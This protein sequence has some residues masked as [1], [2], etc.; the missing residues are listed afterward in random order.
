M[1]PSKCQ[2][3]QAQD[4]ILQYREARSP[5]SPI[6]LRDVEAHT[7]SRQSAHRWRLCCQPY[8]QAALYP[9]KH[10]LIFIPARGWVNPRAMVWLEGLG[11]LKK[12]NHFYGTRARDLLACSIAPQSSPLLRATIII[13]QFNSLLFMCRVNSHKANYTH[14]TV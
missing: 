4:I 1:I 13:I 12:F 5:W 6:G 14:S 8:A 2:E 11:K 9:Q 3:T 10:L 7:F